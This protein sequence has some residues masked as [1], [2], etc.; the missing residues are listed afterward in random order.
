MGL[1]LFRSFIQICNAHS[2]EWIPHCNADHA[3]VTAESHPL[4]FF[5]FV[6]VVQFSINWIVWLEQQMNCLMSHSIWVGFV[7]WADSQTAATHQIRWQNW[8]EFELAECVR[9]ESIERIVIGVE[10]VTSAFT[11]CERFHVVNYLLIRMLNRKL[12]KASHQQQLLGD[13]AERT[14][15]KNENNESNEQF[16]FAQ[17]MLAFN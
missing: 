5:A 14:N 7:A 10:T 16:H 2:G 4:F 1:F 17:R 11:R 6:I 13:K 9:V 12:A 15:K 8:P 3:S